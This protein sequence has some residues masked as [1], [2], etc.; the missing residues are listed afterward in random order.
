MRATR[1]YAGLFLGCISL[2]GPGVLM[3][4]DGVAAAVSST[5]L[6]TGNLPDILLMRAILR[7]FNPKRSGDIYLVFESNVFINDIDGLVVA[8][9]HGSP[10]QYDSLVPVI[11]AGAGLDA[12]M[13]SRAVTPYDIAPTLSAYLGVKPP[14]AAI[15]N[16]LPEVLKQ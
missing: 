12:Q 13:V 7:N 2:S 8:S 5:A 4:F 6:R 16:P 9:T 10:W 11:L 3:K 14:S 15:G 1:I